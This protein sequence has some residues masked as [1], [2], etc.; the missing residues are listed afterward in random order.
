VAN[1][2]SDPGQMVP[3]VEQIHE[4]YE[5][6]PKGVLVDGGFLWWVVPIP[7]YMRKK[8]CRIRELRLMDADR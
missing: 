8:S 7:H 6:Y 3:M 5:Q 4:R 1:C 2:G